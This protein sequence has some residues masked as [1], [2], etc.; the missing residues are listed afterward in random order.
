MTK[1]GVEDLLDATVDRLERSESRPGQ[2]TMA[3]E[4]TSAIESGRHLI[5]QAGT[6]TGK[7]LGYLVPVA[8]SGRRT[9][10]AT[11][12]K[13]LQDQ[14]AKFD[15]PLVASVVEAELGHDLTFAVLK[16]RSNYLC[17]Q[18]VDELNDRSQQLN[19][20]PAGTAA[21][22][23]LIEWSHETLTGDSGDIDWSLSDNAWRQVSV[24]SEECPGARK[25]PRGN[26]CFA[27]RARALAQESD[28]IVVNTHLYALDIA[29]DGSILPD[30]DVVIF[31]E[32]HQLEDVVS[33]SASVA[34]G[35]GRVASIAST[36]RS[37]IAD[38][39]LYTRFG[40]AGTSLTT[41]LAAR[42]G[43]RVALPLEQSIADAL[44]EL[45]LC[46]DDALTAVQAISSENESVKQKAL[47]AV[48][49]ATRLIE[50]IDSCLTASASFVAW[51][52]GSADRP[53]LEI[54][55]LNVAPLL[56]ERVWTKRTA[57]LTSATIP[58]SLPQ[59][60][61]ID[62]GTCDAIDVGSPFD[63][64]NSGYIYCAKHLPPPGTDARDD[65]VNQEIIDLITAA[66]GRTLAL[67]TT[68]RAMHL[69]ADVAQ[70][71]TDF[72]ILRQDDLPKMALVEAF[73]DE[74]ESCL[75]AT[76]GFFQGVDVPGDTLSLVII[77]KIPFPRPDDPL[78]SARRDA[79]GQTAFA[80]IDIPIAATQ[81][82]QAA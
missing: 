18:R 39:A 64:E 11:Y 24:T 37:V 77:D 22:R 68:Y 32:A 43:Q 35:P 44:V 16:G 28:V 65:A 36:I 60:V 63:Y 7:S 82:A 66:G 76:A 14:L 9:V 29:S 69:A 72:P 62:M 19:V 58:A 12:T 4:I 40:R 38:D 30:H 2:V 59:R 55:P 67:F 57:V 1:L 80:E 41:A 27:E 54:A 21:V 33:S 56:A 6:G 73:S 46:T 47:R 45:R 23:K 51:V 42:S 15:L 8:L 74:P 20:D 81:L 49:T 25:C 78:L 79:I 31:D 75:F 26:D 53:L 13:A 70:E 3:R 48:T 52:S 50:Q 5:V 71:R 10:V 17:L 61:G 34:I